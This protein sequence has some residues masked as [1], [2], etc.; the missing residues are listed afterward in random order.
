M[1]KRLSWGTKRYAAKS[2][3]QSVL[4]MIFC[5]DYQGDPVDRYEIS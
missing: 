4:F 1:G 5:V 3:K 2:K